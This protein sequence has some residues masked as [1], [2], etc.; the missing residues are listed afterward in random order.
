MHLLTVAEVA[1]RLRVTPETVRALIHEG[2][3]PQ[4]SLRPGSRHPGR[5]G[6]RIPAEAVERLIAAQ[7]AGG[8]Q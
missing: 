1:E 3:L 6:Y 7:I 4:V 5:G 2:H 8:E